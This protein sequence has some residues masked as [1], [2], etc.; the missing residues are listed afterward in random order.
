MIKYSVHE[1]E[2]T[3]LDRDVSNNGNSTCEIQIDWM[4]YKKIISNLR[5]E[6]W[7]E[8]SAL[9]KTTRQKTKK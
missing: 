6:I 3:I 8:L 9:H 1:Y 4:K 7:T 2:I 5:S